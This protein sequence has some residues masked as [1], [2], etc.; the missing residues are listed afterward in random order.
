M[1]KGLDL[2]EP[3]PDCRLFDAAQRHCHNTDV[4]MDN[5]DFVHGQFADMPMALVQQMLRLHIT[6]VVESTRLFLPD[7]IRWGASTIVHVS[8]VSGLFGA[9]LSTYSATKGFLIAFSEASQSR[10][11]LTVFAC[12]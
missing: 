4:L 2:A 7:T 8:S 5:A 11:G 1:I 10:Y 12:K 3:E 6:G 9:P